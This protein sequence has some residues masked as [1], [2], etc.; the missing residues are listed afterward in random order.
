MTTCLKHGLASLLAALII[1][2]AVSHATAARAQR[3]PAAAQCG[4]R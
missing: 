2:A 4:Q 1:G 3:H